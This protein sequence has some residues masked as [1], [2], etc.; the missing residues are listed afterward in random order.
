MSRNTGIW[1]LVLLVL[2][3]GGWYF[4]S[5]HLS[6]MEQG[7]IKIGFIGPLTGDV[8]SI[9]TLN[10]AAVEIAVEEIN[11]GG[12]I[13]GR[14]LHVSYEDGKCD[15]TTGV[16]AA[17][18]LM[19]DEGLVAILGGLC[20]TETSAFGPIAMEKKI[21]VISYGS[22]APSLSTMGKYFFRTYPSDSYQGKFV[23]E[24]VY[25]TL[26]A[27]T[28]A[29][30][31]HVSDYGTGLAKTFEERFIELGGTVLASEGAPQESRDYRTPLKKIS[32]LKP[33][34]VYAVLYSEG[35]IVAIDQA[36]T[37]GVTT[38]IFGSDIWD[39]PKVQKAATGK[40][41][42]L[43]SMADT[44]SPTDFAVKIK[45]KTG[46]NEVPNTVTN[47]YDAVYVLA[48]ALRKVGTGNSEKLAEAIRGT[49]Y[50]GISGNIQFDENGDLTTANY[51][52]KRIANG[53]G[54]IVE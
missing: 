3:G 12:G 39:D 5:S 8:A 37:L 23:A 40:G 24:Y 41:T 26:G 25:N 35:A 53:I 48:S 31:Y 2:L 52:V 46:A 38:Q 11:A 45:A 9:G 18:K 32:S 33:D 49:E 6:S 21:P 29:T 13:H 4:A 44:S 36:A 50:D 1:T 34:I 20:S 17:Q 19:S 7:P 15:S 47:A 30:I 42:F 54:V 22:S 43:Y 10:K 27:R 14:P 16:S 28:S 51:I